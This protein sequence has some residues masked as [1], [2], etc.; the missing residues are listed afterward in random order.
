MQ[1][2]YPANNI[3]KLAFFN[4]ADIKNFPLGFDH[5]LYKKNKILCVYFNIRF[6]GYKLLLHEIFYK[7]IP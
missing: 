3:L 2:L 1:A 5:Q 7:Q 6:I 4:T